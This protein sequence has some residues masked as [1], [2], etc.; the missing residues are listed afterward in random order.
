VHLQC[1]DAKRAVRTG[2][3]DMEKELRNIER[4][5]KQLIMDIKKVCN[6]LHF[7]LRICTKPI[8]TYS[9]ISRVFKYCMS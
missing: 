2:E 7:V 8:D 1:R 6:R 9:S 3:R 5:E 4:Q